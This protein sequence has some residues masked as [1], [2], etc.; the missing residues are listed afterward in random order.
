MITSKK[1][2]QTGRNLFITLIGKYMGTLPL[3]RGERTLRA[4]RI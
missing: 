4:M 1:A 3:I 2:R